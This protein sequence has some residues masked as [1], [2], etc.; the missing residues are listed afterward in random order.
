MEISQIF[1]HIQLIEQESCKV[2][3]IA[4]E[5]PLEVG[6]SS[7]AGPAPAPQLR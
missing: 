2:K 5:S 1:H 3:T 6:A 4:Y 7:N